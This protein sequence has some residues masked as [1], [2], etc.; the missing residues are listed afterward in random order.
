MD[1]RALSL[2][3]NTGENST[4]YNCHREENQRSDT[5][6]K[7]HFCQSQIAAGGISKYAAVFRQ[8]TFEGIHVNLH[9]GMLFSDASANLFPFELAIEKPR[10]SGEK[11]QGHALQLGDDC[12]DVQAA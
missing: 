11:R 5:N 10:R 2:I 4:H 7:A 6:Q 3:G 9:A 8:K 1:Q 12:G